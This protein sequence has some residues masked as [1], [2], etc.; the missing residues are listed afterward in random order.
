MKWTEKQWEAISLRDKNILVSAAAGS[1]KTAVLVERIKRLL[2]EDQVDLD[3]M[4]IVTF[5]NAAASE[6]KEK[7]VKALNAELALGTEPVKGADQ[8][9]SGD[10][11]EERRRLRDKQRFLRRQLSGIY[12]CNISTFHAFAMEVIR[13]YFHLIG[14]EPGFKICDEGQKIILQAE[15]LEEVFTDLFESGDPE[16]LRFLDQYGSGKNEN[17][18]KDMILR[19][20]EFIQSLPD[21]FGWLEEKTE[22]LAASAEQ[23]AESPAFQVMCGEID[24]GLELCVFYLKEAERLLE[25]GGAASLLP[26]IAADIRLAES[27]LCALRGALPPEGELDQGS[28]PAAEPA[29]SPAED[30]PADPGRGTEKGCGAGWSR[31]A[32]E[33]TASYL[34]GERGAFQRMVAAKADKENYEAVKE[35]VTALRNKGRDLFKKLAEQ[36]AA[37]S[38]LERAAELT[39]TAEPARELCRLTRAF[40]QAYRSRKEQKN[41]LDF[42]DIEHY[43]LRILEHEEA[44][45]EYREKF[46]YIFIDEYQDSNL[47]QETLI[48]RIC[49]ENNVFMVGDVKQSIYKFRLAEPELFIE[50]YQ[51]YRCSES[52]LDA[53]VD[54]NQNFRSKGNTIKAVNQVFSAVMSGKTTGMDYDSDAALYQGVDYEGELDYPMSLHLVDDALDNS[55]DVDEE[56]QDMKKAEL[57]AYAAAQLIREARGKPIYDGK[58]GVIRPLEN[59]DIVIL[60]RGAKGYADLYYKAL[61]EEGIAA[62]MD[63]SDGYFDTVE[64][65]IFMNLLQVIDNGKQD[66]PLLSVL[67]SPIFDF[68]VDE[69]AEIRIS[70]MKGAYY[71]AFAGYGVHGGDE[72]LRTK[73]RRAAERLADYRRQAAYT[74]LADLLSMLIE[75]TGYGDFISAIPSGLQRQ[76]NLRALVD[77]AADYQAG[78]GKGLFGFIRY[79]DALKKEKISVGQVKLAGENDDV[80]RIMTVHKSKGLEFPYVLIGG[81]GRRFNLRQDSAKAVF[82]KELGIALRL[83]DPE[84]GYYKKTILQTL[85]EQKKRREDMAE[86]IRTLYVA[87]TRAMDQL[88]LMGTVTDVDKT[89]KDYGM[90]NGGDVLSARCYLDMV[91]P[92]LLENKTEVCFHG[93]GEYGAV[94]RAD[95]AARESLRVQLEHGFGSGLCPEAGGELEREI[96]RRLSYVYPARGAEKK[97]KYS[98]SELAQIFRERSGAPESPGGTDAV[99]GGPAQPPSETRRAVMPRGVVPRF[100]EPVHTMTAAERGTA[101]H[102][103]MEHI[104]FTEEG[105]TPMEIRAFAQSMVQRE[106]MTAEEAEAVDC[107]AL[108]AFFR[109]EA[110]VRACRSGEVYREESFNLKKV[111]DGEEIIVQGT[112]DCYFRE[113]EEYILLDYKSGGAAR[114]GGKKEA[115]ELADYYRP[116]TALYKEALE[117]IKGIRVKSVYL[118]LFSQDRAVLVE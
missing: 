12:R 98:V 113:G 57:E 46:R 118:Y 75:D 114:G 29:G 5:S 83:V 19:V 1:G 96:R 116:Q 21:P 105:K 27:A 25:E 61:S 31:E 42:N 58:K 93:R 99:R 50:K 71:Q 56:I 48:G 63:N 87:F 51:R 86:E 54:L 60:L 111:L 92:V 15:A 59:R 106:M 37:G 44:A 7:I 97:S 18:V 102:R 40:D 16:F 95:A 78:Q 35:D 47:V 28:G 64:I 30:R 24:S 112:I 2:L 73:C 32:F 4:L 108:S 65:Q 85:I 90:K 43:A 77:K 79:I 66:L 110:G 8:K 3:R 36:Y 23:F 14:A 84:Q 9:E 62:F 13:R 101:M 17:D 52:G 69:L 67:R 10:H 91:V 39:Q 70:R 41:L 94:R 115:E 49:R 22:A 20:H 81:L 100:M 74:P 55:Q 88:V 68:T 38:L 109:S 80:V 89:M 45:G 76:A 107:E 33:E 103:V 53:K 104:P 34:R 26:K 82:H 6:M 72:A 117:T 11:E